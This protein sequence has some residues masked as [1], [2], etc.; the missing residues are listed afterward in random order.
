MVKL[1][2]PSIDRRLIRMNLSGRTQLESN[3]DEIAGT[4]GK[5]RVNDPD[6]VNDDTVSSVA[7]PRAWRA[8]AT[9]VSTA[10]GSRLAGAATN[11]VVAAAA[12][13]IQHK[14]KARE[15]PDMSTSVSEF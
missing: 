1:I 7:P 12:K 15:R 14:R 8:A 4:P 2:G 13:A 11:D 9:S 10:C 5:V 3:D 6:A